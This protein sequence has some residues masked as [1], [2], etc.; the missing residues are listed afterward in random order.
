MKYILY[1]ILIAFPAFVSRMMSSLPVL[2]VGTTLGA[3]I[4]IYYDIL[5][6][7]VV[8]WMTP[9]IC[10][11]A[12]GLIWEIMTA[13]RRG[14]RTPFLSSLLST[15]SK[16]ISYACWTVFAVSV[17]HNTGNSS[18]SWYIM[19]AI[20]FIEAMFCL[21]NVMEYYGWSLRTKGIVAMIG[22]LMSKWLGIPLDGDEIIDARRRCGH[23]MEDNTLN[24]DK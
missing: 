16:L 19:S 20:L 14:E 17:G 1:N 2:F 9:C 15:A 5:V 6:N 4:L 3:S 13:R 24:N 12:F 8:S 23:V 22:R 11:V 21:Q 10:V 18:M 7:E